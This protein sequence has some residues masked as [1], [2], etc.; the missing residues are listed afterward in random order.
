MKNYV[1][2][3]A[4]RF[5]ESLALTLTD[6]GNEVLVIDKN[7]DIVNKLSPYV[8]H[9]VCADIMDE[10]I[11]QELGISNMDVA[12]VSMGSNLEA[13][14]LAT[15][16][17][18]SAGVKHIVCKAKTVLHSSVLKKLGADEVVIPEHDMGR[19][20]AY[21]LDSNNVVDFFNIADGYSIVEIY[22]PN[23]WVGSTIEKL[24]VRARY[25]INILGIIKLNGEFIGNPE[26][27]EIIE[28]K[29]KLVILGTAEEFSVIE[30]IK[31]KEKDAK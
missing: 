12:I 16:A 1:V 30:K 31:E 11:V 28:D 9:A 3:G 8:T 23:K 27:S 24:D 29:D 19:K 17:L 7:E 2:I 22:T 10:K 13:S 15:L 14:V 21:N 20:L 6:L 26:P 4:G 5:G 18:Q 25:G